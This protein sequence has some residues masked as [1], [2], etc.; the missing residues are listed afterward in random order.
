MLAYIIISGII[1]WNQSK[2]AIK[3]RNIYTFAICK[4]DGL[5]SRISQIDRNIDNYDR[6]QTKGIIGGGCCG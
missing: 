5:F 4:C 6:T 2:K 3:V 1:K